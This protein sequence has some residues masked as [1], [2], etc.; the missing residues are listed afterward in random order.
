V[1]VFAAVVLVLAPLQQGPGCPVAFAKEQ[2]ADPSSATPIKHI[3]VIFQENV[4]FDHYFATYPF[5][6]NPSGEPKFFAKTGTPNV[7]GLTS[8]GLLTEN[9][10]STQPFRLSRSQAATCDQDHDYGDEQRAFD[11]GLMDKFPET[12]GVGCSPS[13]GKGTGLVMGYFDGN[14]TT[15]LWNYAQH[16]AMS[17]NSYDTTF[18][19][20]TP[21]A[22]NLVSGQTHGSTPAVCIVATNTC[23]ASCPAGKTCFTEAIDGTVISDPQPN[24][25]VCT[26]RDRVKMAGTNVGDLLNAKGVTWGFFQGGFDLTVKNPDGS[27]GCNRTHTSTITNVKKVDYIPHHQPFQYFASTANPTHERP[28]SVA[29]I[30]Q[31]DQAN[32][33]YDIADFF[34]ALA[35]G[36][37]PAVS[38]LKAAGYQDGHAGYSDPLD[39]QTFLVNT[40]NTLQKSPEWHDTAVIIAYDDSDGWYDH[41]MGPI[42]SQSNTSEDAL[43]SPGH[44]GT[45]KSA[46]DQGRCGYGPRLPLLVISALAKVNYVDHTVTDQSSILQ[47]IEDNWNL[48]RIGGGSFDEKAG[49]LLGMFDFGDE[50][51]ARKLFLDPSTGLVIQSNDEGNN[52]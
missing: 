38:Y 11:M 16:F 24:G 23:L 40:L 33:Q 21:G 37:M 8:P 5:A 39:E 15:A 34:A 2:T 4:S 42:V 48:G 30:G 10:N 43:S 49:S 41:A 51:Q 1:T 27:T 35:N 6:A 32:H 44:C 12:V 17:D 3:V 7:N 18:G 28:S 50:G 25:D 29:M 22:L 13:Y 45:A 46:T 47:L 9:P 14:T 26:S 20:S 19:P 31:T 36:N 52:D